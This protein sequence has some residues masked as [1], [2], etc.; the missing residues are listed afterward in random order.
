LPDDYD[1]HGGD[2]L[3]I[4]DKPALFPNDGISAGG[5]QPVCGAHHKMLVSFCLMLVCFGLNLGKLQRICK[6]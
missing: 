6:T 5:N 3:D 1:Y 4:G 2:P